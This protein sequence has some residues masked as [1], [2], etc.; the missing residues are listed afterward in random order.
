MDQTALSLDVEQRWAS[1]FT[2]AP[3]LDV[4][5]DPGAILVIT[6]PSGSGKTTLLRQIAGLEHPERG[7][8]SCGGDVWFDSAA[9]V[10]I[11]PQRR[12]VGV[13]FQES[14][15]FPHLSVDEN[16]AYG[17]RV[18]SQTPP[19]DRGDIER[20]LA[21]D[22]VRNR[23]PRE[24]SGGEAQRVALARALTPNP[25]LLLLDEPFAALDVP[26]RTRLRADLRRLLQ[27][28]GTPAVLVTHDRAEAMA[29]GDLVAV[30]IGGRIRQVGSV[31]DVF[32]RP[33]DA[34]V[35]AA[36]GVEAVLPAHV[37]ASAGGLVTVAIG[38]A[39]LAVAERE[40]LAAGATVYAC[41]RAEDV[42]LERDGDAPVRASAR[43]HLPA[44]VVSIAAEGPIDRVA[45]DCGFPLDALITRQSRD[46]LRLAVGAR[47][48]AAVKATSI[49]LV[50][51]A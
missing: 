16:I 32:S 34:D 25:R 10:W 4:S 35:A 27:R 7:R 28:I 18:G 30:T 33:A 3:R 31:A 12:H 37:T 48:V 38:A 21:I 2:S 22:A 43:N 45:L 40:P 26:T 49:H 23:R 6:G 24:L 11:G 15:L 41:I 17:V 47:V 29:M 51:R 5:L 50:P 19:S 39:A 36:L 42:T 14:T 46:D 44:T 1:G 9:R 8:I 13:V 20:I